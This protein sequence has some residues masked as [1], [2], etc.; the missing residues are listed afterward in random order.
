MAAWKY[1][2]QYKVSILNKS[3][4]KAVVTSATHTATPNAEGNTAANLTSAR[5][6]E[7]DFNITDAG[8]YVIRF[9][10][11]GGGFEEFLLLECRINSEPD[12][13][14]NIISTPATTKAIY[15]INGVR[16][17][18]LQKGLNIIVTTDGKVRKL[19]IK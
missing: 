6:Y 13:I 17:E 3:T 18:S 5:L 4:G 9:Q 16:R 12:G 15:D 14:E 10:N 7:L 8:N 1:T 11:A 2:P 19:M